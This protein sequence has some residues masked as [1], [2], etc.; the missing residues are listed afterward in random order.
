M[1]HIYDVENLPSL[2]DD[3][4][5]KPTRFWR[6]TYKV[7]SQVRAAGPRQCLLGTSL[8]KKVDRI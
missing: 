4:R 6:A 1:K 5:Y 3:V 7:V 2:Y 8:L